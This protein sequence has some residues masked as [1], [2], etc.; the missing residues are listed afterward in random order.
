MVSSDQS[1][2]VSDLETSKLLKYSTDGTLL[3]YWGVYGTFPGGFWG[4][5]QFS[6]D[7]QGNLYVA[8][9]YGGRTQKFRPK[10]DAD[11]SKLIPAPVA[12]LPSA[13]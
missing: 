4:I 2:W 1:V 11:R 10:P 13:G 7:P 3:Y 6:V 12:M 8:E 9:T 5:L